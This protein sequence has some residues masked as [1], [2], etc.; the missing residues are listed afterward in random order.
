MP[1]ENLTGRMTAV[2]RQDHVVHP[3]FHRNLAIHYTDSLKKPDAGGLRTTLKG[4]CRHRHVQHGIMALILIDLALIITA[5][6]LESFYPG[7][8]GNRG[9]SGSRS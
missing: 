5:L 2:S 1:N 4:L 3:L 7:A 6:L 8:P 9:R